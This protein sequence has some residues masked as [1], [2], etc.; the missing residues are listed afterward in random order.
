MNNEISREQNEGD[1][2]WSHRL[3]I[4]FLIIL[5]GITT[6][7]IYYYIIKQLVDPLSSAMDAYI[8]QYLPGCPVLSFE[9]FHSL[10]LLYFFPLHSISL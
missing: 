3:L 1:M 4:K 6:F 7:F 10:A 8:R 9:Q 2:H 5:L